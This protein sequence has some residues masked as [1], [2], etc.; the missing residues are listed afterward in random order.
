MSRP[1]LSV[2]S[3]YVGLGRASVC[4]ALV[5]SGSCV[6]TRLANTAVT[7]MTSMMSAPAAPS[8]FF[9][10]NRHSVRPAVA[11][12]R[13]AASS[14]AVATVLMAIADPRVQDSVEE[15]DRQ[16]RQDHH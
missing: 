3:Q 10:T 4:A 11:G 15:V 16:V 5:A 8:G 1:R 12:L 9:R 2:P 7:M 6:A 14:G 13:G